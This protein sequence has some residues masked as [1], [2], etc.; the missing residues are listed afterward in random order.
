MCRP[1]SWAPQPFLGVLAKDVLRAPHSFQEETNPHTKGSFLG[2]CVGRVRAL[3][4]DPCP[5]EHCEPRWAVAVHSCV[6]S[7]GAVGACPGQVRSLSLEAPAGSFVVGPRSHRQDA[8]GGKA[9]R[10]QSCHGDVNEGHG[11]LQGRGAMRGSRRHRC[12]AGDL[13]R[14]SVE[15]GQ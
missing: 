7:C 13:K 4:G 6:L 8:S 3:C 10:R 5:Q 11:P 14:L 9:V 15:S 2:R 1:S 12:S